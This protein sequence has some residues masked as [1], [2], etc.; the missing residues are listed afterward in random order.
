M[1][2][3]QSSLVE[4]KFATGYK[5][6]ETYIWSQE[7]GDC[8]ISC[9][10][11]QQKHIVFGYRIQQIP[12]FNE[13]FD[14]KIVEKYHESLLRQKTFIETIFGLFSDAK[15]RSIPF[16]ELRITNSPE[17]KTID[18][19]LLLRIVTPIS[20]PDRQ[21]ESLKGD[22]LSL[23][24]DD[25]VLKELSEG[26]LRN[27]LE[28]GD[29]QL[30]EIR[31]TAQLL[32][33][34]SSYLSDEKM[35]AG[36]S[37]VEWD[38]INKLYVPCSS[39]L[40]PKVYNLSNFYKLLQNASESIELRISISQNRIFDVE[41]TLAQLYHKLVQ[42][43]L[44]QIQ[45]PTISSALQAFSKYLS[46]ALLYS[47]KIQVAA[48]REAA[49]LSFANAF[50][51]QQSFG[52]IQGGTKMEC[53]SLKNSDPTEKR[54]DWE[55]CNHFYY[56]YSYRD[57]KLDELD[58]TIESCNKRFLYLSDGAEA[59]AVFRLPV[60]NAAGLPGIVAK[61]VKPF[62]QPNPI[63]D[64]S[65]GNGGKRI[66]LGNILAASN[67]KV[68]IPFS[69]PLEDLTKHGLIV[70]A[71]GS[72]KTN[73]TLNF[74]KEL[75][76]KDVHFML[77][78]PVKSEYYNQINEL[79]KK[80]Y[81]GT[82]RLHRYNFRQPFDTDA[83]GRDT[84]NTEFLRFN[85]F[86]PYRDEAKGIGVSTEK[87]IGFIQGCLM[88][89][90]P[91]YGSMPDVLKDSLREFYLA[92]K[93]ILNELESFKTVGKGEFVPPAEERYTI[94]PS[95]RSRDFF[96]E[97]KSISY[98]DNGKNQ[99]HRTMISFANFIT[100]Y[101]LS[102]K[103]ESK[104]KS[105]IEGAL[106]RRIQGLTKGL[107][108][109][110][111]C[112]EKWHVDENSKESNIGNNIDIIVSGNHSCIIEL[113][114]LPDNSDKSLVMAFLLTYLF[115]SRGLRIS[116]GCTDNLHVT[117]IEEA[118]R[119]LSSGGNSPQGGGDN[120]AMTQNSTS[121]IISIFNDMLAEIRAKREGI[122]IVEQIP[123]KLVSE[124]I[125][126]TNLKIMHRLTDKADKEYLGNAMNMNDEQSRFA[127][128]LGVGEA[129]IFE[130][131]LDKPILVKMNNFRGDK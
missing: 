74:I 63:D 93:L 64:E 126:N 48:K 97:K 102:Q 25:Y 110:I 43:S 54:L 116:P 44:N 91:L 5:G 52:E 51:G 120:P 62:Y 45:N 95:L 117:I 37:S 60:A 23:V 101:I 31:K 100:E 22:F 75:I 111:F 6:T 8:P 108:G 96:N 12:E 1:V 24:P 90:F 19:Y 115:E 89:A 119:L 49:A 129:L 65:Q 78:E 98:W 72:G 11:Q 122:F 127:T 61:P 36:L 80:K 4:A 14:P 59:M 40:E 88:A 128:T 53:F 35:I 58:A 50:C 16:L 28:L 113:D 18:C 41:K 84:I 67:A 94:V 123:T 17:R 86:V 118:H 124:V 109:E 27:V 83:T 69:I 26:E 55:H 13:E 77:I 131:Q 104:F 85:P 46:P 15:D 21:L 39:Y 10:R 33:V 82:Q 29:K 3:P 66:S 2:E 92:D 79:F 34:G 125:K 56:P 38:G 32:P 103:W 105:E 99:R 68:K 71:T 42:T 121:K 70:G 30:V 57:S 20:S 106:S 7:A 114:D 87:H 47:I 9:R 76:D 130:E 81:G 73:T 112:P 107:L